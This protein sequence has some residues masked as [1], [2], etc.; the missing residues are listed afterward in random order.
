MITNNKYYKIMSVDLIKEYYD[1]GVDL[2]EQTVNYVDNT[3]LTDNQIINPFYISFSGGNVHK[4]RNK[5]GM[6]DSIIAVIMLN[7]NKTF[8]DIKKFTKKVLSKNI[9]YNLTG[10]VPIRIPK[11]IT[12]N[13]KYLFRATLVTDEDLKRFFPEEKFNTQE[14]VIPMFELSKDKV[15][16]Y[17]SLYDAKNNLQKLDEKLSLVKSMDSTNNIK[18][19]CDLIK[20]INSGTYWTTSFNTKM[21]VTTIFTERNFQA[22]NND[23]II[24]ITKEN[25]SKLKDTED[26][27]SSSDYPCNK[28]VNDRFSDITTFLR[29]DQHR[30]FYATIPDPNI[31]LDVYNQIYTKLETE[32]EKYLFLINT[33]VSKDYAHLV[34]MNEKIL[35]ENKNLI[36]KYLG[37][38]KYAIGY[39]FLSF[40]FEECIFLNK[41]TKNHRYVFD[42][43]TAQYLPVFPFTNSNIKLNP[44]ITLLVHDL[45]LNL[46]ENCLGVDYIKD[47]DGY[48][49]TDLQT[50][51]RRLNMFITKNPN[52]DIFEGLDWNF[53]GLSGSI[54]PACLQKRSPLLDVII[55]NSNLSEDDAY[56]RFVDEYYKNSDI[57]IMCNEQNL[58]EYLKKAKSTYELIK[59]NTDSL[60]SD[61]TCDTVKT[62]SISITTHFFELTLDDFNKTYQISWTLKEYTDNVNDFRVRNYLYSYYAK[63]KQE[64]NN[65]ILRLFPDCV[66]NKF[67]Q[68][69]ITY[70]SIHDF[71]IYLCDDS[72]YTK[73]NKKETDIIL[74]KSDFVNEQ[75]DKDNNK[76]VMKI[77]DSIRFKFNFNKIGRTI[78]FFKSNSKD[79]FSLVAHFHLPTV[80]A[81]YQG[82]N[83]YMTPSCVT[84]MMTGINIEYK[85]FAGIR[86]PVDIINKYNRRGFGVILNS[87]E[88]E[89][90]KKF[91]ENSEKFKVGTKT[92][93]DP[94]FATIDTE[95]KK[96]YEYLRTN[97]EIKQIYSEFNSVIDV[98]KFNTINEN[99]KINQLKTSFFDFY[100]DSMNV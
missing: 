31:T 77:G 30:K 75:I 51:K 19:N 99:G 24:K 18:I 56:L 36:Q 66:D 78:E 87:I 15:I 7:N 23:K 79:F 39:A 26:L 5:L 47:Y 9:T 97:E 52:K 84:A 42:I 59:K 67:V 1:I 27:T 72:L 91:N 53:Y 16:E 20:N 29:N 40:Y 6:V 73:Y 85:Y 92:L 100:Y 44:Y 81:Y 45:Q 10:I 41:T 93:Y 64:Q 28:T 89:Q 48:G 82:D 57:D 58:I 13:S 65:H 96:E 90:Y 21:N 94:M 22:R 32:K 46:K 80:R 11:S 60:D 61:V 43:N 8:D 76:I 95:T 68:D 17:L 4:E 37:A 38:F 74:R 54:I 49:V 55:K 69:Y 88:L 12:S 98:T 83:V 33:L 14:I 63:Y 3:P 34:L 50:F 25:L 35:K 62:M 2:R 71:T 70:F 86:D